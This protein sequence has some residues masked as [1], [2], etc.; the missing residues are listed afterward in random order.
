MLYVNFTIDEKNEIKLIGCS[1][2][3]ST[4]ISLLFSQKEDESWDVYIF[5]SKFLNPEIKNEFRRKKYKAEALALLNT[6]PTDI[7]KQYTDTF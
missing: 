4:E 3:P 6:L 2:K 5:F 1:T 7:L